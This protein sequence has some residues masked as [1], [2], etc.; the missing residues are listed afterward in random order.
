MTAS[1]QIKLLETDDG[2]VPFQDWYD[3]LKNKITKVRVRRRLDRIEL[4]NVGDA[5]SVGEGVCELRFHFGAWYRVYFTRVESTVVVL[6]GGG[7]KSTQNSD[8]TKA[9]ALWKRYK[10]E[11]ERYARE[12]GW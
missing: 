7:D 6:V 10:D 3:S 2:K 5:Q 8:I 4:G 9:K 12:L 1:I 11:V